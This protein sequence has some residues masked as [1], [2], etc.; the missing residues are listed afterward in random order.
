[1]RC[2][3]GGARRIV[4]PEREAKEEYVACEE[5]GGDVEGSSQIAGAE[6]YTGNDRPGGSR[7]LDRQA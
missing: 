5:T 3:S 2:I 1:M 6:E 4:G 7:E